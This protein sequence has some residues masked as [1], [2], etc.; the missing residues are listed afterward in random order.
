MTT[1][2]IDRLTVFREGARVTRVMVLDADAADGLTSVRFEN[3]PLALDDSSMRASVT[4]GN[5][6]DVHV[7]LDVASEDPSLAP[8]ED[9]GLEKA[10]VSVERCR[11]DVV[12]LQQALAR[13]DALKVVP[14]PAPRENE[15]PL[16]I[17]LESRQRLV[18]LRTSE[19]ERI[20]K[21]LAA[22]LVA[23]KESEK[24][25]AEESAR[26]RSETSARNAKEH[27][28][29]KT[30]IVSLEGAK[31]GASVTLEYAV[32]GARWSPSYVLTLSA[33]DKATLAMRALVAQRSGEDWT[34]VKLSLST[35]SPDAW[36]E[37]PELA[38][39]RIGRAQAHRAK[40]VYREPPEGAAAL[41]A[42]YDHA[43]GPA[44][45]VIPPMGGMVGSVGADDETTPAIAKS[46]GAAYGGA[47][48]PQS[49][50]ALPPPRAMPPAAAPMVPPAPLMA[51]A[52]MPQSMPRALAKKAM[53]SR[54]RRQE[55]AEEVAAAEEEGETQTRLPSAA[56]AD[57]EL[58]AESLAYGR[59]RMF[60]PTDMRR[61]ELVA[62]AQAS[63]Y[64]EALGSRIRVDVASAIRIAID[65]SS[66]EGASLPRGHELA[67]TNDAYDYL[68]VADLPSD[69][70][71]D[72]AF[73]AVPIAEWQAKT[74][75]R[76]VAVPR[77]AQQ[78]YRLLEI[79]SPLDAALLTGPLDVYQSANGE[80]TYRTTTRMPETPPRGLVE[81]GLGVEPAIKIARVTTFQEE[82]AGL[83]G[84]S[85]ALVH[86]LNVE[87]RNLLPHAVTIE[88]RERVPVVRK[89]DADVKIEVG[90]VEPAWDNWDQEQSLRGG[91]RWKISLDAGATKSLSARYTI[92]IASKHEL[93]GGNRRES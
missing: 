31:K 19:D 4:I 62:I 84:G 61:G 91:H 44:Q 47:P 78:V 81:I 54:A 20:G 16:P 43:A 93:V 13:L 64:V 39:S 83:L 29:R 85:L 55:L 90:S 46:E 56:R 40:A 18:A 14:R 49:F 52:A 28:L 77:E 34:G 53:P 92:K 22:A 50:S 72:G 8:A 17:P 70:A 24:K 23:L 12:R 45:N 89:D 33:G 15:P 35:A 73:H 74:I 67:H 66:I 82:S 79:E 75:L 27:E 42:D 32:P 86:R 1:S 7:G 26:Y 60:A 88:V 68:Y 69:V 11:A 2:R 30:A 21:A 38:K 6:L 80:T 76:H 37:L 48:P 87:L 59:L 63:V 57:W 5:A 36:S 25:L 41:Y 65:R 71:S 51:M 10:L 3:L 58:A 9:P